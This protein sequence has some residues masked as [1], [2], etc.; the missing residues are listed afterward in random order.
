MYNKQELEEEKKLNSEI[1]Q[2]EKNHN[3][4]IK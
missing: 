4:N 2:E 1:E 3:K